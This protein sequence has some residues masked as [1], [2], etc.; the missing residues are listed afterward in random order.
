MDNKILK[1]YK[2][3]HIYKAFE[4]IHSDLQEFKQTSKAA[5]FQ[6]GNKN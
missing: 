1:K 2:S 6:K 5:Q 3:M 4:T